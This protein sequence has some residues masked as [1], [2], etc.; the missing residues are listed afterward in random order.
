MFIRGNS[1]KPTPIPIYD[2]DVICQYCKK[3][4][5][6]KESCYRLVG[7]PPNHPI[8]TNPIDLVSQGTI[9]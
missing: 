4:R 9:M 1:R 5:H 2:P 6:M 3:T 8:H 7:Y